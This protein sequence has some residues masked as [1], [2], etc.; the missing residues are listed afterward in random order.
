MKKLLFGLILISFINCK[1]QSVNLNG[2][3]DCLEKNDIS[4]MEKG[5][6]EFES[7]LNEK[8]GGTDIEENYIKFLSGFI[9]NDI[10]PD[11]FLHPRLKSIM[12]EIKRIEIWQMSE[13]SDEEMETEIRLDGSKPEKISGIWTL[14]NEFQNCLIKKV[15]NEGIKNFLALRTK[16]ANVSMGLT[17]KYI[18]DGINEKDL[19]DKMNRLAIAYGVYYEFALNLEK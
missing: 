14:T 9:G 18:Y 12:T 13:E 17:T 5:L 1:S 16:V 11:F 8:Y 7:L 15:S 2:L 3:N 19:R 6:M 4:I 10:S